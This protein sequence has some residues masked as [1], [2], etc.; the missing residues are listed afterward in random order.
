MYSSVDNNKTIF[1]LAQKK[2]KFASSPGKVMAS[3]FFGGDAEIVFIDYLRKY[4]TQWRVLRQRM[5]KLR[6][7]V[8][9]KRS[10]K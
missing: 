8:K 4:Y 5:R 3:V 6:K 7:A 2:A 9:T 10:E 1:F